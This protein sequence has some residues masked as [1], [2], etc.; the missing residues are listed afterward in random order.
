MVIESTKR[1]VAYPEPIKVVRDIIQVHMGLD[2]T[3]ILLYNQKYNIPK[4][5]GLYV[6][7][8]VAN[9]KFVVVKAWFDPEKMQEWFEAAVLSEIQVDIMSRTEEARLRRYE[10]VVA[11]H[12]IYA[13]NMMEKNNIKINK[14]PA[15]LSNVEDVEDPGRLNRYSFTINVN[16]L[17]QQVKDGAYY[18]KF[19]FSLEADN[20]PLR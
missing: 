12:G 20:P 2:D 14:M 3:Q 17:Y 7:L 5:E 6:A 4:T 15:F 9:E 16:S 13:Q 8:A 11:L 19:N 18:D 10:A 1:E